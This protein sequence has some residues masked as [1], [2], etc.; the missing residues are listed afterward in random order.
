MVGYYK[1]SGE[2]KNKINGYIYTKGAEITHN[3]VMSKIGNNIV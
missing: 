2:Q 3:F 1:C